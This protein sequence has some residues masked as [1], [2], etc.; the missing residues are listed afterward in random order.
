MVF[1]V[2]A[3]ADHS[4]LESGPHHEWW[5]YAMS[6]ADCSHSTE[7]EFKRIMNERVE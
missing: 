5:G 7:A 1:S 6:A 3:K 2:M 4:L